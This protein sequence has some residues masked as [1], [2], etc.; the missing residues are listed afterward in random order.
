MST[1]SRDFRARSSVGK[2]QT[3]FSVN[4]TCTPQIM[5]DLLLPHQLARKEA[6]GTSNNNRHSHVRSARRDMKMQTHSP[7]RR[8]DGRR[9]GT[10]PQKSCRSR[11]A[12]GKRKGSETHA[13][14]RERWC[15]RSIDVG[16]NIP[17]PT[18][19]CQPFPSGYSAL[20]RTMAAAQRIGPRGVQGDG[21]WHQ[22]RD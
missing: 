12:Y 8:R 2:R 6:T 14:S 13:R 15:G 18:A 5:S 1:W 11:R 3:A 7:A 19:A 10:V 4:S 17:S 21:N 9:Q 22:V 20:M 16:K